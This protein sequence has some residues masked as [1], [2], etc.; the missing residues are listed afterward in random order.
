MT[1][2]RWPDEVDLRGIAERAVR[3]V[4]GTSDYV[5]IAEAQWFEVARTVLRLCRQA[6][7]TEIAEIRRAGLQ[8]AEQ[9]VASIRVEHKAE[10]ERLNAEMEKAVIFGMKYMSRKSARRGKATIARI[11]ECLDAFRAQREK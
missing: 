1:D 10:V 7:G 2:A 9:T 8:L 11:D 5:S 3:N 4:V 6:A